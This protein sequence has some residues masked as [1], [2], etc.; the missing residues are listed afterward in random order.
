MFLTLILCMT[1][2]VMTTAEGPKDLKIEEKIFF[3]LFYKKKQTDP[4]LILVENPK[5]AK[6]NSSYCAVTRVCDGMSLLAYPLSLW[7]F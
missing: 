1:S 2:K 7:V 4:R 6:I 5:K 3:V